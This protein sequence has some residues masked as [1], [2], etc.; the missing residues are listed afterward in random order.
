MT[1]SS[2]LVSN[3]IMYTTQKTYIARCSKT[4]WM[5]ELD[6]KERWRGSCEA[7]GGKKKTARI[8]AAAANQESKKNESRDRATHYFTCIFPSEK[9]ITIKLDYKI[10]IVGTKIQLKYILFLILLRIILIRIHENTS[11]NLKRER[12]FSLMIESFWDETSS[13]R[14]YRDK[15]NTR[16]DHI[17][18]S[19]FMCYT[20]LNN[21][22][23]YTKIRHKKSDVWISIC[24][25]ALRGISLKICFYL[26]L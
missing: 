18:E 10:V 5:N 22:S 7:R 15:T 13:D 25:F 21:F 16:I 26:E 23:V 2:L 11:D 3:I 8:I 14:I 1:L 17:V 4:A 24:Y 6:K 12:E 19:S 9:K 20:Y